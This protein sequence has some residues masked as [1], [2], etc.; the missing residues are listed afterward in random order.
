MKNIIKI[1]ASQI[2]VKEI[3]GSNNN[4][5]I[6]KYAEETGI[7]GITND[8]IPWCSTFVN[9]CCKKAGLEYTGKPNARSWLDIG[10]SI[11]DP[12][13]GDIVVLWRNYIQSWQGHVA[14][15]LGFSKSGNNVF[16][17]GGNQNNMVNITEYPSEKV[18]G[19][20]RLNSFSS[21]LPKPILKKGKRGK[22]VVKLQ[23][24]LNKL[25]YNC[26]KADG[27]FGS[28]TE[29]ALKMFQKDNELEVTGFY[30]NKT[31]SCLKELVFKKL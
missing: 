31:S 25:N 9:W 14:I 2:G 6:I 17:L 30:E 27:I 12:L 13:P 24:I 10:I 5:D 15:F 18:L 20:R 1:A 29:A 28:K 3:N 4:P 21:L 26:G 23:T 19:F 16:L 7:T 22:E 8:E 11:N